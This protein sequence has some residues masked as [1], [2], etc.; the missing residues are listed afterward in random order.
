[1][2]HRPRPIELV[3]PNANDYTRHMDDSAR[4][5]HDA[6]RLQPNARARLASELIA[7]LEAEQ[8]PDAEASWRAEIRRRMDAVEDGTAELETWPEVRARLWA[9]VTR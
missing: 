3:L 6:L 7:S 1:M 9:A 8:D 2:T 4:L 5:L